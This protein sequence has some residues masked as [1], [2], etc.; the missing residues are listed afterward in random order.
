MHYQAQVNTHR[1]GTLILT[2]LLVFCL[3]PSMALT[4][5]AEEVDGWK[6][7]IVLN[8]DFEGK[9]T[10]DCNESQIFQVDNAAPGD[11][12]DG[13]ITIKNS[14]GGP[15]EVA[16]LTIVS[17]LEDTLLYDALDLDI[18]IGDDTVY[19]GKYGETPD[20][21]TMYYVLRTGKSMELDVR[22]AFPAEAGNEFQGKAM[23]STWTFEARYLGDNPSYYPYTVKYLDKETG[24]RLLEDKV[25]YGTLGSKVVEFAEDIPGYT[26]DAK[27]KSIVISKGKNLIIFYYDK[28]GNAG[29]PDV[30]PPAD[31]GS[32]VQTGSDLTDGTTTSAIYVVLT[33][34]CVVAAFA[35]FLRIRSIK[36]KVNNE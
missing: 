16:L 3:L 13:K 28:D 8:S 12:W 19:S 21:I 31:P 23:D 1:L 6:E 36:R 30:K 32:G 25:A 9:F 20:P 14:A 18:R 29:S 5:H 7:D 35:L 33:G 15:V 17:D 26:P 2:L 22:I 24:E 10:F 11:V 4:A 27:E 34:L